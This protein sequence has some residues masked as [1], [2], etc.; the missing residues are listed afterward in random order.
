[1]WVCLVSRTFWSFKVV[2]FSSP[3]ALPFYICF[4]LCF[5]HWFHLCLF[6][7]EVSPW[8]V[9]VSTQKYFI[10]KV[11]GSLYLSMFFRS[12]RYRQQ[13]LSAQDPQLR[14]SNAGQWKLPVQ[15]CSKWCLSIMDVVVHSSRWWQHY[16]LL[17]FS[18]LQC[19]ATAF[20]ALGNFP[21]LLHYNLY[22]SHLLWSLKLWPGATSYHKKT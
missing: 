17:F 9:S 5:P 4:Y 7:Q 18:I 12:V 15:Q 6:L 21:F 13:R 16:S 10:Q 8:K 19:P 14:F 2:S 3:K 1:M 20:T 11:S 22:S